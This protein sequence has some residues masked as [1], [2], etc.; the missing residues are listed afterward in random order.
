MVK[1]KARSWKPKIIRALINKNM[2]RRA[3]VDEIGANSIGAI[4]SSLSDLIKN[5]IVI[6][7]ECLV[8]KSDSV[9]KP[10]CKDCIEYQRKGKRKG[11]PRSPR[12]TKFGPK[13]SC[14]QVNFEK[15]EEIIKI[16]PEA[17]PDLQQNDDALIAIINKHPRLFNKD[18]TEDIELFKWQ[19]KH[20]AGF[21]KIMVEESDDNI[22]ERAKRLTPDIPEYRKIVKTL[23]KR[24][25]NNVKAIRNMIINYIE[26]V[27]NDEIKKQMELLNDNLKKILGFGSGGRK[28]VS[29]IDYHTSIRN[30]VFLLT[31]KN[32]IIIGE[33][34]DKAVEV[35]SPFMALDIAAAIF[36]SGLTRK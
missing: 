28:S 12:I 32:E 36:V 15:I 19:L 14:L 29:E 8:G 31:I 11:R 2:P 7:T 22:V 25:S 23:F 33:A 3:L 13:A 30:F 34:N 20:S 21:F 17:I 27:E 18:S 4:Y 16:A 1:R 9:L 24:D 26:K 6:E 5:G 35:V 10:Y